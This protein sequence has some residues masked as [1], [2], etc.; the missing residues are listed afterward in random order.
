MA[1]IAPVVTPLMQRGRL[2]TWGPFTEN[3]TPLLAEV[4]GGRDVSVQ[5]AGTFGGATVVLNG[6]NDGV[7]F[8]GSKDLDAAAISKAAAALVGVR[9]KTRYY[10]PTVSGG[11]GQSLTVTLF[12]EGK[13]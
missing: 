11:T 13:P 4:P 8:V 9:E 1:N 3:D 6:S 10:K 2:I 7:N 5:I 12:V